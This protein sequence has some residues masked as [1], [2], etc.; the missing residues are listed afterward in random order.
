M[1][2]S[3]EKKRRRSNLGFAAGLVA[4]GLF[5]MYIAHR[6]QINHTFIPYKSGWFTPEVGYFIA[7]CFFAM[8]TYLVVSTFRRSDGQKHQ[9]PVSHQVGS[10]FFTLK[11]RELQGSVLDG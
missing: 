6:A 5:E 7:F 8:A 1:P 3:P 11:R 10:I 4:F 9:D 2:L